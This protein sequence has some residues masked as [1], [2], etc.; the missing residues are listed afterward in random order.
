MSL[1][2]KV[3][4][5]VY[6]IKN[7]AF[8]F[9]IC[10]PFTVGALVAQMVKRLP[11]MRETRVPFLGR[12]EELEKEMAILSSTI[13][14]K[15]PWTEEPGR[16]QSMGSQRVRHDWATSL[17]YSRY[18]GKFCFSFPN[19]TC[20]SDLGKVTEL[21]RALLTEANNLISVTAV[22]CLS[23]ELY[24]LRTP[25]AVLMKLLKVALMFT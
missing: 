19:E 7:I 15:I 10:W 2:L 13:A 23:L 21:I 6:I 22:L 18:D 12:E 17:H 24:V 25:K 16:L 5:L 9:P 11:T 1:P 14:W 3:K 20:R 8:R 4:F